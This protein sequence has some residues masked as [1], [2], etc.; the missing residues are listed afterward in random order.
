MN[1]EEIMEALKKG[2]YRIERESDCNCYFDWKID[3][4]IGL[5]NDGYADEC[6]VGNILYINEVPIAQQIIFEP[7]EVLIKD[8]SIEDFEEND[9]D[10]IINKMHVDDNT[11]N[12]M[13]D[14]REKESLINY[15]IDNGYTCY[16]RYL[17][18]FSNEYDCIL[19]KSGAKVEDAEEVTPEIFVEKYLQKDDIMTQYFIGFEFIK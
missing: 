19:A 3:K 11:I 16:I 5:I 8:I 17:R 6:W 1:K 14:N 2:N 15:I 9:L 7:F 10:N 13:H 4:N 12:E 18:N